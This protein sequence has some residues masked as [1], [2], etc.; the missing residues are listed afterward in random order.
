MGVDDIKGTVIVIKAISKI[1]FAELFRDSFLKQARR[2][3]SFVIQTLILSKT[4]F[5]SLS[6][7]KSWVRGHGFKTSFKGKGPDTTQTSYRFRQRDP[8][9]FRFFRTITLTRGVKAVG[10][11]LKM[12][13]TKKEDTKSISSIAKEAVSTFFEKAKESFGTKEE[14]DQRKFFK[15]LQKKAKRDEKID[16][17]KGKKIKLKAAGDD[18]HTHTAVVN[19]DDQGRVIGETSMDGKLTKHKHK[20]DTNID[21]LL[22][23]GASIGADHVHKLILS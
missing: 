11:R 22:S 20:I 16:P 13:K 6:S 1:N 23:Q 10:G 2:P 18:K 4:R 12:G 15:D 21:D 3:Q 7:A 17:V 14:S 8:K 9:D 5:K 19:V